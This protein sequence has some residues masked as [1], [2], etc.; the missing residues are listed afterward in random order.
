M[1]APVAPAPAPSAPA[2]PAPAAPASA[3]SFL[4]TIAQVRNGQAPTAPAGGAPAPT[5]LLTGANA[6]AEAVD[7]PSHHS[8][9]QPRDE[10]GQFA[11]LDAQVHGAGDGAVTGDGT[12]AEGAPPAGELPE[13]AADEFVPFVL[14]GD[15]ARGEEDITIE[16]PNDPVVQER[17]A[18]MRNEGMRRREFESAMAQVEQHRLQAEQVITTATLDPAGF[19]AEYFPPEAKQALVLSWLS[20]PEFLDSVRD[21]VAVLDDDAQRRRVAAEARLRLED[22]RKQVAQTLTER[23]QNRAI[24]QQVTTALGALVPDTLPANAREQWIASM[25]RELADAVRSGAVTKQQLMNPLVLPSVLGPT[26]QAW[27]VQNPMQRIAAVL[28][29][30]APA[31]VSAPRAPNAAVTGGPSSPSGAGNAAATRTGP[32]SPSVQQLRDQHAQRR[33]AAQTGGPGVGAPLAAPEQVAPGPNMLDR[34]IKASRDRL[35]APTPA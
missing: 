6:P 17:L 18:R 23:Q 4:D 34:V 15:P 33:A 26:L 3:P 2:A 13:A 7:P 31:S 27:G 25:H 24:T 20:D 12:D 1:T 14:A 22:T 19:A 30:A 10:Q 29:G 28:D 32:S 35:R 9:A 11:K 8:A 5:A 21:D 16:F